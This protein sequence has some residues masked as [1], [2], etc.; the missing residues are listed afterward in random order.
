MTAGRIIFIVML[1]V[2]CFGLVSWSWRRD[3][4]LGALTAAGLSLYVAGALATGIYLREVRG[5]E[6]LAFDEMSYQLEAQAIVEG[7]RTGRLYE[8][9]VSGGYPYINA[10][11][12]AVWGPSQVPMRLVNA[13]TGVVVIALGFVLAEQLFG[14]VAAARTAACL[15]LFSPALTV[16]SFLNLKERL[17]GFGILLSLLCMTVLLQRWKWRWYLLFL[18]SLA[19]L[20][21]LR[22][23]YAAVLGWLSIISYLTLAGIPWARRLATGTVLVVSVG[24]VLEIVAGTF[25]GW[26]MLNESR[27]RVRYVRSAP[28]TTVEAQAPQLTPAGAHVQQARKTPLAGVGVEPGRRLDDWRGFLNAVIFTA[29]GRFRPEQSVGRV[30][31]IVLF[32]DW[33]LSL[34]LT[35]LAVWAVVEQTRTRRWGVLLPAGFVVVM[36]LGLAWVHGDEWT[37]YRL[38]LVYW[39]VLLI[40]AGGGIAST[41]WLRW[42]SAAVIP[43]G[44]KCQNFCV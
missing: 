2:L 30:L 36:L 21:E 44:R 18:A 19:L 37:T 24:L 35:P 8:P 10:A 7:W 15:L 5:R 17:L 33:L 13:L 6:Y 29:F 40:L 42:W 39:P 38:R 27:F 3:R 43:R 25:L 20:G 16:W 11:A 41:P 23:Y 12:V 28:L 34:V 22:Y 9:K 31:A 26:S 14:S 32:P 4:I 1:C